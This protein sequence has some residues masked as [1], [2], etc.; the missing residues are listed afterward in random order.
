MSRKWQHLVQ[1]RDTIS[2]LTSWKLMKE[3]ILGASLKLRGLN[4]QFAEGAV[5]ETR[6]VLN[7]RIFISD[8][9][10][11][12]KCNI[13]R[14]EYAIGVLGQTAD[15]ISLHL[16]K[17]ETLVRFKPKTTPRAFSHL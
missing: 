5:Q 16:K 7:L 9:T 1:S 10:H 12:D 11:V 17:G 2:E 3:A 4:F 14:C 13:F 6:S 8:P 15:R